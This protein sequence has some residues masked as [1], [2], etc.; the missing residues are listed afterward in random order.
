MKNPPGRHL[1]SKGEGPEFW[2]SHL[3]CWRI[4]LLKKARRILEWNDVLGI[5]PT[6][7]VAGIRH[8][9]VGFSLYYHSI[10]LFGRGQS[11]KMFR[12]KVKPSNVGKWASCKTPS[13]W[14]GLKSDYFGA[15]PTE[16]D[17]LGQSLP[18]RHIF[19]PNIARLGCT[20][21]L[22]GRFLTSFPAE[23]MGGRLKETFSTDLQGSLRKDSYCCG[24]NSM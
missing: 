15:F 1:L 5:F 7:N 11:S 21:A 23:V 17:V 10:C 16:P 24:A 18:R 6:R 9:H 22:F 3:R 13:N 20:V 4:E 8:R 14:E 2:A 19:L 12:A